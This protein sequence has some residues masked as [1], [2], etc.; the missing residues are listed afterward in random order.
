MAAEC[1]APGWGGRVGWQDRRAGEGRDSRPPSPCQ[2]PRAVVWLAPALLFTSW[3]REQE[4]GPGSRPTAS[5]PLA[6]QPV[7]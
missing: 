7:G 5:W 1:K 6:S 4:L 3:E 2:V